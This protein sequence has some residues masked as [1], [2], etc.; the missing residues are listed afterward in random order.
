MAA[1]DG[2]AQPLNGLFIVDKPQGV[3]S[4][5]VVG[6]VR[7]AVHMRRV[8]HAGTLD[9]MA[10]GVLVVGV[11]NAT[12]LL[13]VIVDHTKT[14]AATIR[15]GQRTATDDAD[16]EL[17][18]APHMSPLP[19]PDMIR[20]VVSREFHGTIE[21]VPNAYSAIK[22]HGRRAYDLARAGEHV[23]LEARPV[24]IHRFD[25]GDARPATASN[26]D[27]VLDVDVTV[28]CSAGTYI[29]AL[30]RDLG[31]AFGCGAHLTRLR[32]LAVGDFTA[33]DPHVVTAH[34]ETREFTNRDGERVTRAR[35]VLDVAAG[36]MA[37]HLITMADAVREAMPTIAVSRD[38]ARDLR[39]GRWIKGRVGAASAA[40]VEDD[41]DVVA[42]VEQADADTVRPTAVFPAAR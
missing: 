31:E 13:N 35:A 20:G 24:T 26:G 36:D 37:A 40:I 23:E 9:P 39:Y 10:T 34:T 30:A 42:I 28:T 33:D 3:T 11:G 14:Y 12:R 4:H 2:G 29:R 25:V 21:Q 6:A 17:V 7:A 16:G 22:V 8:G 18:E 41:G 38:E 19:D 1:K 32:R 5:D 15:F 27:G